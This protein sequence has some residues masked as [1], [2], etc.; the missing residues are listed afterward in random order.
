M[1][2][3][4]SWR[5]LLE[6]CPA[7]EEYETRIT[8]FFNMSRVCVLIRMHLSGAR[9]SRPNS[10]RE[11]GY[12]RTPFQESPNVLNLYIEEIGYIFSF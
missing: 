5:L 6:K 8:R 12:E 11:R 10:I 4:F 9:Y 1:N 7:R 3:R 2:F